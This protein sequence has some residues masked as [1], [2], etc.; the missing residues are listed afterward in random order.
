MEGRDPFVDLIEGANENFNKAS[1]PGAF[2]VDFFPSM[3]NWPEWLPGMGFIEQARK[4]RKDTD[5]MVE[6]PF[7]WTK[8]DIVS[9]Y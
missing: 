5:S 7:D 6:V 9:V 4:W 2:V 3:K 1:V 8:K